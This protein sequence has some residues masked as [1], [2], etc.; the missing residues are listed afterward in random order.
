MRKS[1]ITT[2][3]QTKPRKSLKTVAH[4]LVLLYTELAETKESLVICGPVSLVC[5]ATNNK[6]LIPNKLK[7]RTD[8]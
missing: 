7:T 3:Y 6:D 2:T 4:L 1:K 8:A 5:A